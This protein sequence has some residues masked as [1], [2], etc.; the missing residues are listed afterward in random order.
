MNF[1]AILKNIKNEDRPIRFLLSRL[2][3]RSGLA[4]RF[5]LK[6]S[7]SGYKLHFFNTALSMS[8]WSYADGR[9]EDVK[10]V[11]AMLRRGGTYVDIGANIG[12]LVLAGA[13]TVGEHG[14]VY[15]FEAHPRLFSLMLR[16]ISLNNCTNVY[17]VNAACAESFGWARFSDMR[18]DDLNQ[19]GN[20][21]ILVP[22]VPAQHLLS[23]QPI[24]LI[25]IDVEGFELF[26]L[27][28]LTEALGHTRSLF[29]EVGDA[30][31]AQFGYRYADIHDL[32][33]AQGFAI[34][35]K[36]DES[37]QWTL[38][39]DRDHQFPIVQNII[40]LRDETAVERLA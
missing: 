16:N 6:I 12:D 17:P 27:K 32:L 2:L 19:I 9:S 20:G 26:V 14:A 22:M 38:L 8:L 4:S 33:T 30:H 15:A 21:E 23:D 11:R 39:T 18:S 31:F 29:L 40:A 28:G 37:G 34:F 5:G 3:A 36:N 13:I 7:R 24:D 35:A 25:K 10:I 1:L